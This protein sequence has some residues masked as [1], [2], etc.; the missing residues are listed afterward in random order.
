MPSLNQSRVESK[1]EIVIAAED[2]RL[3]PIDTSPYAVHMFDHRG[4]PKPTK[5]AYLIEAVGNKI[6][7]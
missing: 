1:T 4:C 5:P 6:R 3:L 2:N 7:R